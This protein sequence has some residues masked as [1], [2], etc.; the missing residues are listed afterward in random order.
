MKSFVV[1]LGVISKVEVNPWNPTHIHLACFHQSDR[2]V[3]VGIDGFNESFKL[4]HI[5][6]TAMVTHLHI[7]NKK[8]F[9]SDRDFISYI[10]SAVQIDLVP[11]EAL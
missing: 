6:T 10:K 1:N 9:C 5:V 11:E 3:A 7:E 2:E 4:T 8:N